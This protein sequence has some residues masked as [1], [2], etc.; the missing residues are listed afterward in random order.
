MPKHPDPESRTK[1]FFRL[2]ITRKL[3]AGYAAMAL[4]T[5]AA[6]GFSYRGLLYINTTAREI[7]TSDLPAISSLTRLRNVLFAQEGYAGKYAIF[8][9]PQFVQLFRDRQK[10]GCRSSRSSRVPAPSG[11][12]PP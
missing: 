9:S 8:K 7:A 6:L 12:A 5:L 2:S 3:I 10:E 11:R 1:S 4:F